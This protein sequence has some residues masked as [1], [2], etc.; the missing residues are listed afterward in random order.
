VESITN[1]I[2]HKEEILSWTKDKT[3]EILQTDSNK[4]KT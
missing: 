2:E 3:E 1:R 4:R